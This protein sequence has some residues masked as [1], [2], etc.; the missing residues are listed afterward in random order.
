[1]VLSVTHTPLNK[2]AIQT[3]LEIDKKKRGEEGGLPR[4]E[5]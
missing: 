5:R 3:Q 1:M 4:K 2:L